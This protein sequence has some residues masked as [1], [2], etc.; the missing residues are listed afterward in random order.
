MELS[1]ATSA[2]G[3]RFECGTTLDKTMVSL[4]KR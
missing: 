1:P 3:A 4:I 2:A